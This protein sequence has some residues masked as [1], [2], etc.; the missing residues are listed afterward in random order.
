M[1]QS[2]VGTVLRVT[3]SGKRFRNSEAHTVRDGK[4]LATEVYFGWDLPH[5]APE[6]SF[7]ENDGADHA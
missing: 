3:D 2:S 5:R 4:L 7:V 1:L 6:G